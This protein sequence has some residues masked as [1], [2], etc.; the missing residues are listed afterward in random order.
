MLLS[1][2]D[3]ELVFKL[4]SALMQ[5]VMKHVQDVGVTAPAAAYPSL[6]PEQRQEVVKAFLGRLDLIDA[7]VAGFQRVHDRHSPTTC[8]DAARCL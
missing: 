3:A 1:R 8:G 7:F 6:P 5:Y 4:H 2:E